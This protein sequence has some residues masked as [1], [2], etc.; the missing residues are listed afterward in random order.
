MSIDFAPEFG[1]SFTLTGPDGTVAKFNSLGDPEDVGVLTELTGLESAEVRDS[2]EDLVEFDGAVQGPNWFGSRPLVLEGLVYGH[3]S[4]EQ[5]GA[6]LARLMAAT[7]AMREDAV[8]SWTPSVEDAIPVFVNLRRQQR[9]SITGA[10]NKTFQA[11]MVARDPRIYS[12]DVQS[13]F[14]ND[15]GSDITPE[16]LG[17]DTA[18]PLYTLLGPM[19]GPITLYNWASEDQLV[20]NQDLTFDQALLVDT[21]KRSVLLGARSPGS[22]R[23]TYTNPHFAGASHG[24]TLPNGNMALSIGALPGGLPA[25]S[26]D[27]QVLIWDRASAT[28][29]TLTATYA[30][31]VTGLAT[32]D[33]VTAG[34]SYIA[35]T[36]ATTSLPRIS[37]V[38][39]NSGGTQVGSTISATASSPFQATSGSWKRYSLQATTPATATKVDIS[40]ELIAFHNTTDKYYIDG[41]T[42]EKGA[43]DGSFFDAAYPLSGHLSAWEG[44][45]NGSASWSYTTQ[46]DDTAPLTPSYASLDFEDSIWSGFVPGVNDIQ[47][48]FAGS[49]VGVSIRADWRHTWL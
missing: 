29:N 47:L 20:F 44:A 5:R 17:N 23:N 12:V 8:L 40:F 7:K 14:S 42:T 39:R 24:L 32:S 21:L 33:V 10:W 13:L 9:L 6:K 15:P 41:I 35:D 25:S 16:N 18:Y 27:S 45:T 26:W 1:T 28:E 30:N 38:F 49:G 22:R 4:L 43:T 36:S 2:G 3:A 19:T 37:F 34:F 31:A 11:A 48:G 46:I